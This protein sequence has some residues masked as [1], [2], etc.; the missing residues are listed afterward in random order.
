MYVCTFFEEKKLFMFLFEIE[1][2]DKASVKPELPYVM[3]KLWKRKELER[4][5]WLSGHWKWL[6]INSFVTVKGVIMLKIYTLRI[7]WILCFLSTKRNLVNARTK[8][9]L[10]FTYILLAYKII[11]YSCIQSK[12]KSKHMHLNQ[13]LIEW[14]KNL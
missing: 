11:S 9:K 12:V 5:S 6:C 1:T 10:S 3:H 13:C 7:N 8:Q 2:L 4:K 14:I